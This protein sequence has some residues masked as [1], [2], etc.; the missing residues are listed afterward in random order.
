[1]TLPN[2]LI[3]GAMKAGTSTLA[4]YLNKHPEVYMPGRL[5]EVHFFNNDENYQKGLDW[6]EDQFA[7]HGD[8]PAVGEKTPAYC[9]LPRAAERIAETL[10]DVKLLWIFRDP[11]DRAYSNYWHAI[12]LGVEHRSFREALELEKQ[13]ES[14]SI[15]HRYRDR[16]V[17]ADQVERFLRLFPRENM[18]FVVLEEL[19]EDPRGSLEELYSFVGVDSTPPFPEPEHKNP[20][21]LPRFPILTR[22]AHRLKEYIPW[23]Q[24][25]YKLVRSVNLRSEPGYPP[26]PSDLE[27]ELR[28][29]FEPHNRRLTKLTGLELDAW[30]RSDKLP[31]QEDDRGD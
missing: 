7:E 9:Y 30:K 22:A 10:P 1:M 4:W 25:L 2:F 18:H 14:D 26:I 24:E 21:R 20:S 5:H 12:R 19:E 11:V 29:F 28:E 6:Y 13:E 27:G 31:S 15:W 8:Q 16:S 17:Y 23:G 3:V